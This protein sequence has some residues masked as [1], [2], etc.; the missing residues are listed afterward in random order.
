[1]NKERS[2]CVSEDSFKCYLSLQPPK[3]IGMLTYVFDLCFLQS[4]EE[5]L[6][7][8][9]KEENVELN[10]QIEFIIK[11]LNSGMCGRKSLF[12]QPNWE[13]K[14]SPLKDLVMKAPVRSHQRSKQKT[15]IYCTSTMYCTSEN[16]CSSLCFQQVTKIMWVS[17]VVVSV[18]I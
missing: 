13:G 10:R 18:S 1:M 5:I 17:K 9:S 15:K 11:Q 16:D 7:C 6:C 2:L 12:S 8:Y 4:M 14:S 3:V